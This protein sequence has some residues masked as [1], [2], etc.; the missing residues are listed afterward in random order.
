MVFLWG[1]QNS[2][3][4]IINSSEYLFF[5]VLEQLN[6]FIYTSFCFARVLHFVIEYAWMSWMF[7][8]WFPA[9]MLL[10]Q[11]GTP[12]FLLHKNSINF[13]KTYLTYQTSH[14]PESWRS[15]LLT[16]A[17]SFISKI[18][19]LIYWMVVDFYWFLPLMA[20]QWNQNI[21]NLPDV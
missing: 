16:T 21:I 11:E 6:T 18:L 2:N 3:Y 5:E 20:W 17:S 12:A 1:N 10:P 7:V 4:R 9:A 15:C 8:F 14:I 19:D 13:H